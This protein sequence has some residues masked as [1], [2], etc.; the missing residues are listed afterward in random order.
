MQI[1]YQTYATNQSLLM[2]IKRLK[3]YLPQ[4]RISKGLS[5]DSLLEKITP[6]FKTPTI[7]RQSTCSARLEFLM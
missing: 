4:S 6:I 5:K 7:E 1:F 2:S 3:L